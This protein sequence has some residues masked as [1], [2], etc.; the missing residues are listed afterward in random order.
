MLGKIARSD[1]GGGLGIRRRHRRI[2]DGKQ[3]TK[4]LDLL[5][6]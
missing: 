1:F 2:A 6:L 4:V 3:R 5:A